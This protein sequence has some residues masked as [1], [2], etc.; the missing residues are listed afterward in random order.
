MKKTQCTNVINEKP[1]MLF[2][3]EIRS[4]ATCRQYICICIYEIFSNCNEI[5]LFTDCVRRN[6]L[7]LQISIIKDW[8][9]KALDRNH[10]GSVAELIR[11]RKV[12][13]H[14]RMWRKGTSYNFPKNVAGII[15]TYILKWHRINMKMALFQEDANNA[16]KWDHK[17]NVLF[18]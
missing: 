14:Q 8:K 5:Y 18:V 1:E 2:S 7:F 9:N 3:Q 16:Q 15:Q 11:D 4:T 13:Q 17:E 6:E 10:C 12:L